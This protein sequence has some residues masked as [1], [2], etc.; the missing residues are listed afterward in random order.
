M[1]GRT[2]SPRTQLCGSWLTGPPPQAG[3]AGNPNPYL[4]GPQVSLER[5]QPRSGLRAHDGRFGSCNS[6]KSQRSPRHRQRGTSPAGPIQLRS[7]PTTHIHVSVQTGGGERRSISATSRAPGT[8]LPR[9][10]RRVTKRT[11]LQ[12]R[13]GS[14]GAEVELR[15][16][17][18]ARG[19][20]QE[21]EAGWGAGRALGSGPGG[22]AH[23]P[24][25]PT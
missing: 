16:L 9:A 15:G 18:G 25:P 20:A 1:E 13:G 2:G 23:T 11:D 24:Y 22:G 6:S 8:S 10:P 19:G 21:R 4:Q 7:P 12:G 17:G 3:R 14:S 5:A